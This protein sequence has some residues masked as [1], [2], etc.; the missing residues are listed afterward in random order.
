M[1]DQG[2][3]VLSSV[4]PTEGGLCAGSEGSAVTGFSAES[5]LDDGGER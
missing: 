2:G 5:R 1:G 4:R 3:V